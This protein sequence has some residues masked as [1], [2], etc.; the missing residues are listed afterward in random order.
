MLYGVLVTATISAGRVAEIRGDD[1]LAEAGVVCVLSHEDMPRARCVIAG[2]PISHSFLPLQDDEIRHEGQPVAL[3]LA[4]AL[5]A[6][7]VGARRVKV[8]H[9]PAAAII[10]AALAWQEIDRSA[11]APHN[12][13]YA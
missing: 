3:V 10:L 8:R 9:E 4:D 13:G 7:E 2:P 6:A 12:T 5:E 1:A 11:V